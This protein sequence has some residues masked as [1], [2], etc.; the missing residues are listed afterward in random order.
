[1]NAE[2]LSREQCLRTLSIIV[3]ALSAGSLL[4]II[5]CVAVWLG[6]Q[7]Q[8]SSDLDLFG[9]IMLGFGALAVVNSLVVPRIVHAAGL[10]ALDKSASEPQLLQ[11]YQSV[12]IVGAALLEG[13]ALANAVVIFMS[14]SLVNLAAAVLL[15]LLLLV[16]FL[17]T[18]GRL[19]SF[20]VDSRR[21][22]A[23]RRSIERIR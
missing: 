20:L 23:D 2:P 8:F 7:Q 18:S 10:K 21:Q 12:T 19:E 5:M 17:P 16:L 11:V 1:M 9:M 6:Q 15:V 14:G 13:A 22:I 3:G 4:F